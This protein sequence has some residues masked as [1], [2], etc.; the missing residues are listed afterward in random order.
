MTGAAT[1]IATSV[2]VR[3]AYCAKPLTATNRAVSYELYFGTGYPAR[4]VQGCQWCQ[5][6]SEQ[7]GRRPIDVAPTVTS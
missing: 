6:N 7:A 1:D 2:R 4:T 3:C 5:G